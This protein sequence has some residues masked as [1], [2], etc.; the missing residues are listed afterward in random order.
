MFGDRQRRRPLDVLQRRPQSAVRHRQVRRAPA[1]RRRTGRRPARVRAVRP[2]DACT[3]DPGDTIVIFSDGVSEAL[4]SAGEEFGDAA[5]TCERRRVDMSTLVAR[6]RSRAPQSDDISSI[7]H[8]SARACRAGV[9]VA[10]ARLADRDDISAS[11]VD[12]ADLGAGI[13]RREPVARRR[14]HRIRLH[15]T[16]GNQ[17]K[18]GASAH[19]RLE[20]VDA[21]V[22]GDARRRDAAR[23]IAVA[24]G[25][26]ADDRRRRS[27]SCISSTRSASTPPTSA[28]P[29]PARTSSR[30]VERL[31]RE[32]VDA[33]LRVRANCAART[34]DRRHHADRRDRAADRPRRSSAARSSDRVRSGSTPRTGRS[35]SSQRLTEEAVT[36][37]RAARACR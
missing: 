6:A 1:R 5:A 35:I 16:T 26:D 27:G 36:L 18:I 28:C 8:R 21:A 9:H 19:L 24:V 13:A 4:N 12:A 11:M 23:R 30:D 32:I 33:K 37:R 20:R 3:L 15:L 7:A 29:A 14:R 25:P 17:P 10:G 22:A 2:G 34:L 31:A